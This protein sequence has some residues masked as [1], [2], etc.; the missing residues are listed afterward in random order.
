MAGGR[1]LV[2][3][4][5]ALLSLPFTLKIATKDFHPADHI[6]F[7][8]NHEPPDNTPYES[9]VTMTNPLN[10]AESQRTRLWPVH[11]V[12]GS[13]GAEIIPEIDG[14]MFDAVVEK[15]MDR[16]V[17]MYSAFADPFGRKL[18]TNLDLAAMLND[19]DISHV[20]VVGLAGDY[21]VS[22]TAIDAQ[23]EGFK[24]YVVREGVKSVDPSD[25]GW[26]AAVR[27]MEEIGVNIVGLNGDEVNKVRQ[28]Q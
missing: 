3:T 25:N 23:K 13:P 14:S 2:P 27:T 4:I 1:Q 9:F 5:N 10:R 11:C 28:L 8:S 19:S 26:G 24:V 15:G 20:Y 7:A 6:S 16:N 17:E 21:C 22:C 18:G 12:Q